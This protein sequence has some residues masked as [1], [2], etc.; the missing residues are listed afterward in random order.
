MTIR[1]AA[2]AL[3]AILPMAA[4]AESLPGPRTPA[5][6]AIV[7]LVELHQA[8][9]ALAAGQSEPAQAAIDRA[10]VSLAR[11]QRLAP[12]PRAELAGVLLMQVSDGRAAI[13]A[14]RE[15]EAVA[16]LDGTIRQLRAQPHY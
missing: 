3:F 12:A 5:P 10:A 1:L 13:A 15:A 4:I 14:M 9:R 16:L 6:F 11:T 7:P 2:A 8:R